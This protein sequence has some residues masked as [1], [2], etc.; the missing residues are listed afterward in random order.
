M[1]EARP[2][3]RYLT[4]PAEA[5]QLGAGADPSKN[6][7]MTSPVRLCAWAGEADEAVTKLEGAPIWLQRNAMAGHLWRDGD[8]ER[9]AAYSPA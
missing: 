1:T 9:C 7:A 5:Y 4:R 2:P 8:C 6:V 3:C